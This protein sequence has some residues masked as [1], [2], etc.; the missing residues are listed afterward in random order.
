MRFDPRRLTIG[1]LMVLVAVLALAMAGELARRRWV[2]SLIPPLSKSQ[3]QAMAL[4]AKHLGPKHWAASQ[5]VAFVIQDLSR[6]Y[7]IYARDYQQLSGGNRLALGPFAVIWR[8]PD[9]RNVRTVTGDLANLDLHPSAVPGQSIPKLNLGSARME[10]NVVFR[11][12]NSTAKRDDDSVSGALP[13]VEFDQA[14]LIRM[15]GL[16]VQPL[17]TKTR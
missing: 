8:S 14:S 17:P 6:G 10:G 2:A 16:T 3:S 15:G 5:N 11:D 7:T 4:A 12:D 9:G 13:K 1:R